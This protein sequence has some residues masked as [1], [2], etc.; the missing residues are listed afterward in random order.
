MIFRWAKCIITTYGAQGS[1]RSPSNANLFTTL[2]CDIIHGVIRLLAWCKQFRFNIGGSNIM[3]LCSHHKQC[4]GES[5]QTYSC[6]LDIFTVKILL[7]QC[8]TTIR[9]FLLDVS[10][11]VDAFIVLIY[12][13]SSTLKGGAIMCLHLYFWLSVCYKNYTQ[14]RMVNIRK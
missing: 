5:T 6:M 12:F 10:V 13:L 1:V 2:F 11:D 7:S 8:E 9:M 4:W 3:I 14:E